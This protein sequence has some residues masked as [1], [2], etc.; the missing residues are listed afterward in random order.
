VKR[1]DWTGL[2]ISLGIHAVL[3]LMLSLLTAAAN[4]DQPMGFMEVEFG[5]F[6]EGR[7][8]QQA[9]ERE[10]VE[11]TV[12]EETPD[13]EERPPVAPPEDIKPVELPDAELDVP[14]EEVIEAPEAESIAPEESQIE[15]EVVAEEPEPEREVVQPL[16]SG[17]L[18]ADE[19]DTSGDDG[20][21]NEEEASAPYQIEGLNRAPIS[22]PIPTYS[23][24]VNA[25]IRVRITV[26][27]QGR[28]IQRIPLI[29]GDPNLEREVMNA[30]LR[31]RFNPLPVDAPQENQIGVVSFRFRLR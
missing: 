22:T 9:P 2:S 24:Q 5:A 23:E 7:P 8:V 27:P 14:D 26:D 21:S 10:E 18:T 30:L 3:F 28:I 29:K 6:S 15:E 31:W 20:T 25:L 16:G 13:T 11:T 17:S 19:G 4:E 1:E 12:E